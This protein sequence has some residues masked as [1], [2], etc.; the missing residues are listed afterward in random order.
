MKEYE[1]ISGKYEEICRLSLLYRLQ[2]L[3]EQSEVRVV[4]CSSLPMYSLDPG[5]WKKF[6]GLPYVDSWTWKSE[7]LSCESLY[8]LLFLYKGPGT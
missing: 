6:R 8:I 1:E 7:A 2:N 4:V 5:T 3:K